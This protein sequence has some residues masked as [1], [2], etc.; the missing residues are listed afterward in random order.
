MVENMDSFYLAQEEPN[1]SCFQA[2]RLTILAFDKNLSETM[3]YGMPCFCYGKKPFCY[4]WSDKKSGNP[5]VLMV[6]GQ[7][8]DHPSLESGS[9]SRMKIFIIDPNEDLPMDDLKEIL[10]LGLAFH[11][12]NH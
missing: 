12:S 6:D 11:N 7:H 3:K 2:L 9:R 8:I 4:L 1:Q 10:S 5:Y